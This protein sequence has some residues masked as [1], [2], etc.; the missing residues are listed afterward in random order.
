L[1]FPWSPSVLDGDAFST[2]VLEK[3]PRAD[4]VWRLLHFTMD[5]VWLEDLWRRDRGPCSERAL[6]FSTLAH[7]IS[8]A[9]LQHGGSGNP[10]FEPA[11]EREILPVS[12]TSAYDKLGNLPLAVSETLLEEGTPRMNA[13]LPEGPAVDPLPDC[14][15]D[16]ELFGAD[17]KAIQP[18]Q[19]LLKPLRGLPAGILGARASVGLNLRTGRAVALV[20]PLDG[21]AGEAA[22]TEALLPKLAAAAGPE[23]PWVV[24]LDRL[25]GT[26]SFPQH[27]VKAGGH[28]LIRSCSNTTFVPDPAEPA[29]ESRDAKGQRIVP[30][31]GWLGKVEKADRQSVR[32]ITKELPDGKE[33]GVVTDLWDEVKYPAAAMLS[34]YQSRWGIETVFHQISDVFSLRHLIGTMP[35]AVLFQLSF[36]LLLYN[37]LHGVRAHLASPQRCEAKKISN[38][39]LFDD[40][41]RQMV[42][43]DELV[44]GEE[45]LALLGEVPT[46][47][48]LR[49]CLRAGLRGAWSDRWWKKSSSGRGGHKKVKT[50]VLGNHT[51]TYRVLQQAQEQGNGPPIAA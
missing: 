31:R 10:A 46:A 33:I 3:L 7:L 30:E 17:G 27:V 19:R 47:A 4:A 9:L 1:S 41:N 42:A 37:T 44:D 18:V 14:W 22:L 36:C 50:R 20:G 38:E 21:D 8:D 49:D 45:L 11:Q 39:K 24:V 16:H 15:A 26:L 23:R 35:K 48:Q 12:M 43:V 34:T 28:F 13:V 5:D 29:R 40:V 25:S 2:A 51:S 6:K 32:R